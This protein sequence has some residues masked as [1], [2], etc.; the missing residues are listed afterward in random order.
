MSNKTRLFINRI[1][2]VMGIFVLFVLLTIMVSGCSGNAPS[3]AQAEETVQEESTD[4]AVTV[5][6]HIYIPDNTTKQIVFESREAYV[7][8]I[9]NYETEEQR[10]NIMNMYGRYITEFASQADYVWWKRECFKEDCFPVE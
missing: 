9:I 2:L 7:Q 8:I 5:T 1:I 3:T 10:Y 4:D 6:H